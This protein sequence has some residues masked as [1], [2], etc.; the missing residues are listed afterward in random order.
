MKNVNSRILTVMVVM[1]Q[2]SLTGCYSWLGIAEESDVN[3]ANN[4][5]RSAGAKAESASSDVNSLEPRVSALETSMTAQ[6]GLFILDGSTVVATVMATQQDVITILT[7]QGYIQDIDA[8]TGEI[9][10]ESGV[11]PSYT[12]NNCTGA[13]YL[14]KPLRPNQQVKVGND[15]FQTLS[16]HAANSLT[17]L[18]YGSAADCHTFNVPNSNRATRVQA[19]TAPSNLSSLA[20][21]QVISQ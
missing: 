5:A 18:S 20:P 2:L 7:Q 3:T 1:A 21:L 17:F 11:S 8:W 13:I 15:Y 4:T 16:A 19:I 12:T 10:D 6:R 9:V 14:D